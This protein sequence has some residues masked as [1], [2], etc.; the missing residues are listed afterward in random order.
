MTG[1]LADLFRFIWGLLYWNTRKSW[2]Q[3]RR[4]R[5]PCPC[6]SPSDSGR[7]F[8]TVCEAS[9]SWHKQ[10]RFRR[11]CPLL[12]ETP[13]GL[14]CSV[15]AA[16]VR[17][18]WGRAFA[19]Y[20]STAASLY[21]ASALVVFA[22]LRS[23]GYPISIVHLVWPGSWHRITEVR[24][25]FF[26]NRAETAFAAGRTSEGMLYLANAHEFDPKNFT[27]GFSLAQRL[28]IGQP[29]RAD[30]IYR[31]LLTDH[32]ELHSTI[33]QAWF[34]SLLSRADY[35]PIEKLAVAEL[36][37]SP[38][39][40]G[41]WMRALLFASRQL[42]TDTALRHLLASS[43][44]A[45]AVWRDVLETELL[46]RA[47]HHE[48]AHARLNRAWNDVPAFARF[49][50]LAELIALGDGFAALDRLAQYGAAIDDTARATLH[51]E[52]YAQL[53]MPQSRRRLIASLLTSPLNSPTIAIVTANLIRHPD[54]GALDSLFKKFTRERVPLTD[55]T[56]EAYLSLYCAL[57][58]AGEK[59]KMRSVAAFIRQHGN[60]SQ[61]TLASAGAFLRGE[62]HQSRI[63]S[64]LPALPM[65][66][67]VHY[68][69]LE[70][71]PGPQIRLPKKL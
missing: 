54:P 39:H 67:E 36:L 12:V 61:V 59:T 30:E 63:A 68:A 58:V 66:L 19:L 6:Q 29:I 28:Q 57:G 2:F 44:P 3:L 18:F 9:L 42:H 1:R 24:G 15:N 20:G 23:V 16:D 47:G 64:I 70:R 48:E 4:G 35:T 25:W 8:E 50:Q 46:L 52:A 56:L 69:L 14:R 13:H 21:L 40:A 5:S 53:E 49:Y 26:M 45:A 7:A 33:N 51:L 32:P 10:I 37:A 55:E 27:I 62:T 31:R 17:P 11:V 34:R 22:F 65:P 60:G 71:F 41:V 38:P 43:D